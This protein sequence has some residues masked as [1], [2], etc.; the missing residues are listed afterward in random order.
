MAKD[1]KLPEGAVYKI[2]AKEDYTSEQ[3]WNILSEELP[4][5]SRIFAAFSTAP[6]MYVWTLPGSGWEPLTKVDE[7][8][9]SD[10][11]DIL[12]AKRREVANLLAAYPALRIDALF[13]IPSDE[14]V[15]VKSAGD[16]S[17]QIMLAAWDYKSPARVNE[18]LPRFVEELPKKRQDVVLEFVEAGKPVSHYPFLLKLFDGKLSPKQADGNG[19]FPM[20][21]LLVGNSYSLFSEDRSRDFSFLVEAGKSELVYDL[22]G[23]IHL[24]VTVIR[25]D[26]P[27]SD[28]PVQVSFAGGEYSAVTGADGIARVDLPYRTEAEVIA[29]VE[30]KMQTVSAEYPLT[31]MDFELRTPQAT[32]IVEYRQNEKPVPG[33]E[34]FVRVEGKE[35]LVLR[36]DASGN[37]IC[38]LPH[39]AGA[40]VQAEAGAFSESRLFEMET[41]FHFNEIV[42]VYY[43]PFI[44]V[45][46]TD[47]ALEPAYP[48]EVMINGVRAGYQTD[49]SGTI[50]LRSVLVGAQMVVRDGRNPDNVRSYQLEEEKT[51]YDLV[52]PVPEVEMYN[53]AL[54][55]AHDGVLPE[56]VSFTLRQGTAAF[57]L[58]IGEDGRYHVPKD[59]LVA[60]SPVSA[61]VMQGEMEYCKVDMVFE[62]EENDYEI[63]VK[64]KKKGDIGII[65][66]QVLV[67]LAT[68]A[69]LA[70]AF[71]AFLL[72]F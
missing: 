62:Q 50:G 25:D 6:G 69:V 70:G 14:Y 38:H 41:R 49:A 16:G 26:A 55:P 59:D 5:K 54:V 56:N 67:G 48:V 35:S 30:G 4:E 23:D 9:A 52:V 12:N 45:T 71:M 65:L 37:A 24:E 27:A 58:S 28:V 11:R 61:V 60:G 32:I 36:T 18:N 29:R 66:K 42:P 51:V 17:L 63:V 7:A 8:T 57:P 2:I 43:D 21:G 10:A 40:L 15:F 64:L 31:K 22:T 47:G 20:Q 44:R 13:T 53:I 33:Q 68:A 1:V 19:C 72:L 46:N 34:V 39:K 3:I